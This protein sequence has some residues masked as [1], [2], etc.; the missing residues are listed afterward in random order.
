M[1]SLLAPLSPPR[2]GTPE[3][4]IAVITKGKGTPALADLGSR[5][6]TNAMRPDGSA[7]RQLTYARGM[8]TDGIVH[9]ELPISSA[10]AVVVDDT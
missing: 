5:R 7:L 1:S 4:Y 2:S 3:N 8:T 9:V 6:R 10:L